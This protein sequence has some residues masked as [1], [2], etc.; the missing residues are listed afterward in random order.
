MILETRFAVM[1]PGGDTLTQ[2]WRM[3]SWGEEMHWFQWV[4]RR[5]LITYQQQIWQLLCLC[6]GLFVGYP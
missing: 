1:I 5:T 6:R 3:L 4:V 2:W